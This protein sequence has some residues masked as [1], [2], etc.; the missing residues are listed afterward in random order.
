MQR[1][2]THARARAHT[3]TH[4]G[5]RCQELGQQLSGVTAVLGKTQEQGAKLQDTYQRLQTRVQNAKNKVDAMT[6]DVDRID[7]E[8]EANEER[9]AAARVIFG[10]NHDFI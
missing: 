8:G 1:W 7:K 2:H 10:S 4:T 5:H 6:N 3:H 9:L